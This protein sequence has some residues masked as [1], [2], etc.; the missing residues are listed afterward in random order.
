MAGIIKSGRLEDGPSVPQV[1]A[2]NFEDMSRKA[3]TYLDTVRRQAAQI[4]R[5]AKEQA[6]IIEQQARQQGRQEAM[7]EATQVARTHVE[8]QMQTLFP[9]LAK[10]IEALQH[11]RAAWIKEWE[12]QTVA[13][14]VAIAARVIRRELSCTPEIS[15]Q[16]L[17]E[18]L[19]LVTG[20]GRLSVHLHPQDCE[21]LGERAQLL[22]DRLAHVGECKVVPDPAIEPG[23][24]R[25]DSEFG[26]IDQQ[27]SSQ[28]KRIEE[29]LI[30]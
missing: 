29:E 30:A 17:Q 26:A 19:E 28:L 4:L 8:Q 22:I 7:Q 18:A 12:Q 16:W 6:T 15:Q 24:C 13:L 25:V 2:F 20:Q 21:T 5:Q 27:L 10:A 14:A 9:A 3:D 11:A 23:G 1:A